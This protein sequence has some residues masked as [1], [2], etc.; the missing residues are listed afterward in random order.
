[1]VTVNIKNTSLSAF[2]V[3]AFLMPSH[4]M[5]TCTDSGVV[6][7]IA[8]T[9][10][11]TSVI[12]LNI[13]NAV[14]VTGLEDIDLTPN[15]T[16]GA[17]GTFG[18][19]TTFCLASNAVSNTT[20]TLESST[21]STP[22]GNGYN[23]SDGSN[24]IPYDV[25]FVDINSNGYTPVEN[26]PEAILPANIQSDLS[27]AAESFLLDI[28]VDTTDADAAPAGIYQATLTLVVTPS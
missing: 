22:A 1:M 16:V 8:N 21:V 18:L 17:G 15:Y 4:A 6:G 12:D 14:R 20:L 3:M 28:R 2:F 7:D 24:V 5:A 19:S 25:L 13:G 10:G 9:D 27:C 23:L 11:C 26:V